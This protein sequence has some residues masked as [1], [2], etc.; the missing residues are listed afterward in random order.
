MTKKAATQYKD[1]TEKEKREHRKQVNAWRAANKKAIKA[2]AAEEQRSGRV[3]IRIQ[4]LSKRQLGDCRSR[5]KDLEVCCG[6]VGT[7]QE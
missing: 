3:P 4:A 7:G 1:W 6:A 2:A 5:T